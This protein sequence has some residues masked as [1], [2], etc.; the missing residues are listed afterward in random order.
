MIKAKGGNFDPAMMAGWNMIFG[1][2][3]PLAVGILEAGSPVHY[4]WTCA[5]VFSLL[6][7]ALIG[8]S[9]AFFLF[10]YLIRHVDVSKVITTT[11]V[12]PII[13]VLVGWLALGEALAHRRR[14]WVAR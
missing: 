8:S 1:S 5:A 7:L 11:L 12:I 4:N 14:L 3:I 9:L 6:Y 10:Y 13:A 2:L